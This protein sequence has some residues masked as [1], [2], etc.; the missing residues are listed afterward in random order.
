M[1]INPTKGNLPFL[2]NSLPK[3]YFLVFKPQTKSTRA[4]ICSA[5]SLSP[6]P[7]ILFRPFSMIAA[8]CSLVISL[9]GRYNFLGSIFNIKALRRLVLAFPPWHW[10]QWVSKS[11]LTSANTKPGKARERRKKMRATKQMGLFKQP[12]NE[13]VTG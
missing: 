4:L 11:L 7:G 5:L 2:I 8:I 12:V 10:P 6:K 3:N 1:G 13:S 9:A